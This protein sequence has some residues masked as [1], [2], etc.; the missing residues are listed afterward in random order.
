MLRLQGKTGFFGHLQNPVLIF[1]T[2]SSD[3]HGFVYFSPSRDDEGCTLEAFSI[4]LFCAS[5]LAL[6]EYLQT[7]ADY[8]LPIISTQRA[9]TLLRSLRKAPSNSP[10][11]GELKFDDTN[12]ICV[13]RRAWREQ[14][15]TAPLHFA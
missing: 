13:S 3:K 4:I 1:I 14:S 15:Q 2:D 6:S 7:L 10:K 8:R 11:R 5:K 12:I 9:R